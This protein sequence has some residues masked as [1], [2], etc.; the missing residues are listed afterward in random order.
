MDESREEKSSSSGPT[1]QPPSPLS[2]IRT[3]QGDVA[4]AIRRQSESLVSIQ[5]QEAAKREGSTETSL[6]AERLKK[7]NDFLFL[8]FGS[9]FLIGAA[10]TG[11]WYGYEAY[12]RKT[13]P[14]ATDIPAN[15][16]VP[17]TSEAKIDLS[18]MSRE[19]FQAAF[20]ESTKD[21]AD[22]ELRHIIGNITRASTTSLISPSQFFIMLESGASGSLIRAFDTHFMIGALSDSSEATPD[23][24]FIIFKLTSFE[25]AFG[26]MLNWEGD[27][28]ED[29]LPIFAKVNLLK[30]SA[31]PPVF[32]DVVVKNKDVR[33][34]SAGVGTSTEPVL[35]YSF[36]DN[37]MLIIT[38][39]IETL[40]TIIDRLIRERLSR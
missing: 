40:Q 1:P 19:E 5:R 23:S 27:M 29:L 21:L 9:V 39:S 38:D 31:T 7:R 3:F 12:L 13:A 20:A 36:F 35:L 6:E 18:G 24:P 26:G 4:E 25:N 28:A 33:V 22:N 14:P 2:Q 8:I 34:L 30:V 10:I 17:V 32:K 16:F 15:R 37:R 11:A